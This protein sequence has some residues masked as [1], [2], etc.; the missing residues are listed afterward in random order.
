MAIVRR[1]ADGENW[2]PGA[3]LQVACKELWEVKEWL[4]AAQKKSVPPS[5]CPKTPT[6]QE[7][8]GSPNLPRGE[9]EVGDQG[10]KA[11]NKA[12]AGKASM[13]PQS[14]GKWGSKVSEADQIEHLLAGGQ[15]EG[16]R[17]VCK[18]VEI[19]VKVCPRRYST[20]N[21]WY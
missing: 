13:P 17:A 20:R 6:R 16:L 14:M 11:R 4:V 15:W 2:M 19:H 1:M 21:G 18:G 7:P 8:T 10:D 3:E 9:L 12:N 5:P